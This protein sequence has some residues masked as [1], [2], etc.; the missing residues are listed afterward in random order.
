MQSQIEIL[1]NQVDELLQQSHQQQYVTL[2]NVFPDEKQETL[3]FMGQ[4]IAKEAHKHAIQPMWTKGG[5]V[6]IYQYAALLRIIRGL[7][8]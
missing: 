2:R 4:I 5:K 8:K 3:A 6:R 1:T 7:Q